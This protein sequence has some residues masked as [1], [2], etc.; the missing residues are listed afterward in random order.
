MTRAQPIPSTNWNPRR[1]DPPAYQFKHAKILSPTAEAIEQ[2][3]RELAEGIAKAE[4][5]KAEREVKRN[6]VREVEYK[7]CPNAKHKGVPD[8]FPLYVRRVLALTMSLTGTDFQQ[9][10]SKGRMPNQV[11]ARRVVCRVLRRHKN[12]YS[13]PEIAK[14]IAKPNHS[15]VI[16]AINADDEQAD[17]LADKVALEVENIEAGD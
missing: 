17:A 10:G 1:N 16:T 8:E 2:H 14:F 4:A 5:R 15:T 11:L 9:F 12:G 6:E 13:L 7:P 3:V